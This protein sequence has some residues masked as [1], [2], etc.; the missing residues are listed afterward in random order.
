MSS[1]ATE[2][3][4]ALLSNPEDMLMET[5]YWR[6]TKRDSADCTDLDTAGINQKTRARLPQLKKRLM[7]K[8]DLWRELDPMSHKIIYDENIP[9]IT[10]KTSDGRYKDIEY[11]RLPL[12]FQ[13]VIMEKHVLHLCGNP[14]QFTLLNTE[15]TEQQTKN[16]ITYKQYWNLRNM[17]GLKTK[18]VAEQKSY[19]SSALLFYFDYKGRIK[20]R[21]LRYE[22]GFVVC[23]HNDNNG[24]RI[25]ECVYYIDEKTEQ[26]RID[27]YDEKYMYS[28]VQGYVEG[29]KSN[30]TL[31]SKTPHGFSEI[32][33]VTKHGK[34]AW[35]AVQSLIE[36][37]E[38]LYNVFTVIQKRHGWGILYIRGTFLD[39]AK[40]IAGAIV[41]NDTSMDGNGSAEFKSPPTPEGM[42]DTMDKMFELIQIGAG[43]TCIL[44]KDVKSSGDISAQAIMLTQ[45][46]DNETALQAVIEWQNVAD[47]MQRLFKEGLAIE[48]VNKGENPNAITEFEEIKMSAKFKIWYPR[49]DTEYNNM[50]I[51]LKGA[52]GISGETLIEKN[53]ESSPDEKMR[54]QKEIEEE[55]ALQEEQMRMQY[56]NN[57]NSDNN[58]TSSAGE[59]DNG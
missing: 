18:M 8:D 10:A 37:Y 34:V 19:G 6:G 48:L 4:K 56:S 1:N 23:S 2:R 3:I 22:D 59:G 40:K 32:P 14:L 45:S 17:D 38:V 31:T 50:L 52:G 51:A 28:F 43:F 5:P 7:T 47:K 58:S 49:N 53:T 55:R 26:E 9:C 21:E 39:E 29:T 44:P 15:P 24:D 20:A 46:L 12:P 36:G 41:L 57:D 54:R 35:D 30:W 11:T 16:F 13:R 42:L 27:C 25:M 33:V